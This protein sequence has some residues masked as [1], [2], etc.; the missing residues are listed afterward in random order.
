M[1]VG[2]VGLEA[3]Y[4]PVAIANGLQGKG[5][6]LVAA[7]TLGAGDAAIKGAL[8][9]SPAEYAQKYLARLYSSPEEMIAQEGLDTVVLISRHSE[10]AA[11][12]E[13]L[14]KLGVDI[15]IPKTFTTTLT[16]AER[17]VEAEKRHGIRIAVGPS[18]RYLPPMMAVKEAVDRGLIGKPFALRICHHHGTIDVFHQSDWYRD[19]REGGHVGYLIEYRPVHSPQDALGGIDSGRDPHPLFEGW[20]NFPESFRDF[21]NSFRNGHGLPLRP[22]SVLRP[23]AAPTPGDCP[24]G[25][26][27][28]GALSRVFGAPNPALFPFPPGRCAERA[29]SR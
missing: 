1:R 19:P 5:V 10:H 15:F 4:W 29:G 8:G 27:P 13:R 17:I 16:D 3:L 2:M 21:P 20:R 28:F 24:P 9:L 22:A 26:S 12:V 7:A 14:A 18:A 11:W 23:T 6:P 25:L